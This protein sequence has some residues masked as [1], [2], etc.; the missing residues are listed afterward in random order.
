MYGLHLIKGES[1][2]G[3][4]APRSN[5]RIIMTELSDIRLCWW[6]LISDA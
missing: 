4:F 2:F 5:P 3:G 6:L 1:G